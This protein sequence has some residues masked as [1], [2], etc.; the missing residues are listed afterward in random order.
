MLFNN[1]LVGVEVKVI[2]WAGALNIVAD[3]HFV[4]GICKFSLLLH[5][6]L[7]TFG[8]ALTI[9]FDPLLRVQLLQVLRNSCQLDVTCA[10][11]NGANLAV[12]EVLLRKTLSYEAHTTHPLDGLAR[13]L[14]RNLRCIEL[15]HG[16][17]HDEV[18]TG[19]LLACGVVN[20]GSRSADLDPR[21]CE[22]VLH[23][24]KL[25]DQLTK[26]LAVVP[27]VTV[28]LSVQCS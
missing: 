12:T 18:L 9:R 4:E 23:A 16:G 3:P 21:L 5:P 2:N 28:E 25:A 1:A 6:S 10:L 15:G 11:V 22:L 26:L 13:D 14:T 17:V 27:C 7:S 8:P 19:L 24:L 20:E